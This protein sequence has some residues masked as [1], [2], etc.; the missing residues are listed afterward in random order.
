MISSKWREAAAADDAIDGGEDDDDGPHAERG[1]L[2]YTERIFSELR[3]LP[4]VYPSPTLCLPYIV[5]FNCVQKNPRAFSLP[6]KK[7]S[8]NHGDDHCHR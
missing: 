4:N 2:N 3:Q 5:P 7:P 6:L 8:C 1:I